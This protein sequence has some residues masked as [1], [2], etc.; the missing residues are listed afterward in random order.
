MTT[1]ELDTAR[2]EAF[3]GRLFSAS[4]EAL[5][6]L[7]VYVG[8]RLGL[9]KAMVSA[10]PVTAPELAARA[11]IHERYAREW[12][13]HQ[14]VTGI[15]EVDDPALT[16]DQRRYTL[17]GAHAAALTD[18]ES[19][20]SMTPLA[21]ALVSVTQTL[22]EVLEAFRSGGGVPWSAYGPDGIE[23]QGDFNRPW[24][25]GQF[26]TEH[27]ASIPD[28]HARLQTDPPAHVADVCCGVGWSSIAI[29]RA[30]PK[31]TID[32]F[33]L[34]EV[35]IEMARTYAADA[36][37]ADRV[38]FHAR[39]AADPGADGQY[40]LVVVVEAI[41]D[42]ARPVEV[43][44]AIRRLVAPGGTVLVLDERTAEEF[45]VPGDDELERLFY[46]VSFLLCLPAGM[47]DQPSAATGTVMRPSTMRKYASE[48]GFRDMQILDIEH[49][50]LRYYRL[51]P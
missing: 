37:L 33:D 48:A 20:F 51:V 8:E 3:A 41:H 4:V 45:T 17:P 38:K 49:P 15:A 21:R 13:E 5:D 30:Y 7:A 14:A 47:A 1:Q 42:L 34:D 16:E 11:G 27:L 32:G 12:L 23:A 24:L 35:S 6:L 9:Y 36:G 19:P 22:P 18:P 25:V 50:T 10:G 39:D 26:A 31:V 40:D 2:A 28:V 29:A 46:G 44:S 43:L